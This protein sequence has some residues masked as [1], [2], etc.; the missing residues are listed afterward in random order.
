MWG[1][2]KGTA[3]PSPFLTPAMTGTDP[4]NNR[5]TQSAEAQR[6]YNTGS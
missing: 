4:K 1:F 3:D 6:E 5:L 2:T